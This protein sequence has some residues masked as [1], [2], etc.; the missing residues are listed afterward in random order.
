MNYNEAMEHCIFRFCSGS[1]QYGTNREDS[2]YDFRG[3]FLAPLEHAFNLFNTSFVGQGTI[4]EH[5]REA[6]HSLEI[7]DYH[8]VDERLR[9]ASAVDH[10]DLNFSVG[11]VSKPGDDEELQELRKFLKLASESNPNI[12]EFLWVDRLITHKTKVWDLI[13]ENR[14]M[15]LSKRARYTFS[16]YAVAQL[17]RIQVH[18]Q[19]LLK[20]LTHPPTRAEFGLPEHTTIPK[21][22][23]K[24]VLS[25][26]NGYIQ[27][28]LKDMVRKERS[29][30]EAMDNWI[31]FKKWETERNPARREIEK[32]FGYDCKHASHLVRLYK[33]AKEIL[34]ERKV[35]VYRPDRE[36]LM[37]IRNGEWKFEQLLEFSE[38]FD[39]ELNDIYEKSDLR[40]QPDHKGIAN[41]YKKICS[42]HYGIDI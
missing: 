35:H 18:R 21:E 39:A 9:L 23:Q 17:R 36:E 12:V 42:E 40:R 16:G 11:T 41:L 15:F 2:D 31:S 5:L 14:D 8:V 32:K 26:P 1:R 20:P 29:F 25:I 19:Y 24:A 34:T 7:G 37:A 10:G 6:I 3:V 4:S 38:K 27:D 13:Q 33:M 22:F 28:G 30:H